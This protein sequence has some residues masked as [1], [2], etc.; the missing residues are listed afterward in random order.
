MSSL[1]CPRCNADIK[2]TDV[3]CMSCGNP[4]KADITEELKKDK[5]KENYENTENF[6]KEIIKKEEKK[7]SNESLPIEKNKKSKKGLIAIIVL[8]LIIIL[9]ATFLVYLLVFKEEKK[10]EVC[11]KCP[12]PEVEIIEK[13][14]TY[15][16][17]NFDGYRF[18]IPLDWNFE[19]NSSD[20]RFINEEENVY[21]LIS[22][23]DTVSYSTFVSEEYQKIYQETLQTSY[24]IS[25][26]NSEEKTLDGK[27]YYLMEGIYESYKYI[28][29]VT[30]NSNG[31]FL[32]EAQFENN[33][34]Y[35]NKKQ[36][37]ID[38]ALS[39]TQNSKL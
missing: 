30:E 20:Y 37:V 9:L 17:I 11:E 2:E 27:Y 21:T 7:V 14:P 39:Y 26:N 13:E 33:S 6:Q 28:I 8:I 32:T 31:I 10:C 35:T 23:V 1:K 25:I 12:E 36:E 29:I 19:G 34:V 24:S 5:K 15:Q 22:N 38:F 4:V 16:Y 3:F 18:K